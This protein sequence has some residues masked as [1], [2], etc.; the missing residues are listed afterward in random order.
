MEAVAASTVTAGSP[1]AADP[2]SPTPNH[3][4]GQGAPNQP[5][6]PNVNPGGGGAPAP[7]HWAKEFAGA[8][9][10][11]NHAVFDKAPDEL[12][13]LKDRLGR[14]QTVDDMLKGFRELESLAGK[15][16]LMEP[17]P[18][19]AT[20]AQ[21]TER[22]SLLRKVNGTPEKPDGYGFQRPQDLPEQ[23]WNQEFATEAQKAM[24]EEGA[25]P[26][27]AK[28]LFDVNLKQTQAAI[29]A[30]QE[31]EKAWYEGQDKL[32]RS[33]AER[34]GMPFDKVMTWAQSA[35]RR[36]GV[37]PDNPIMKNA[38]ALLA[39]A[40]VGQLLTENDLVQGDANEFQVSANVTPD[41]AAKRATAI[42]TDKNDPLY[43]AYWNRDGKHSDEEVKQARST[44]Q[45][46]SRIAHASRTRSR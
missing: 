12:K 28:R 30:Q 26:A 43:A 11:L 39:M 18:A 13:S 15:K 20:D 36:F 8:D 23:Y 16:G 3:S 38:S 14:Y 9:G 17:L 1:Q 40:R 37:S 19:N 29:K 42:Q 24:F 41:A 34:E 27:L 5:L 35:G 6:D 31:G 4:G 33:V 25:S 22:A 10:K 2:N 21:K 45:K 32:A 7:D 46:F 44:Q